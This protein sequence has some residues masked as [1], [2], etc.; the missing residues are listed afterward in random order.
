MSAVDTGSLVSHWSD[1][2]FEDDS[3]GPRA[4]VPTGAVQRAEICLVWAV[5]RLN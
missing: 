4:A 2:S 1:E 3:G 5:M